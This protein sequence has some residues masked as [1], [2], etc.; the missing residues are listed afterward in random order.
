[1][2]RT[3]AAG[4]LSHIKIVELGSFIAG[5][6]CGQLL[7]DL[8]AEVIK[9]EPPGAGD[10]MRRW[11]A[12]KSKEGL[13][14]WWPVIARNKLSVTLDLRRK[15][16]REAARRLILDADVL[17]ENFR[18]GTL[19][20][21][22]LAPADLQRAKPSLIISRVSAFG[23]TGPY[24][25]RGGFG[26]VAEAAAGL[27]HLTG[28]PDLPPP[29]VGISI[30]DSLAGLF[31][32]IGIL[33][34]LVHRSRSMDRGQ[35][36]DVS[37]A[38]SVLA[39]MESVFS[40]YMETG[41]SRDRTGSILPGIAPSNLYP[42]ANGKLVLIAANADG[43]FLRL[44]AAM[45]MPRLADDP[46]FGTHAARGQHQA[47]LDRIIAAWTEMQS[48]DEIL[49]LMEKAGVPAGPVNDAATVCAD[50]HFRAREMIVSVDA[51]GL[52][53]VT[54]QGV[55]PKLSDSPG[56][57]RWAGPPLGAHNREILGGRLK[58]SPAEIEHLSTATS[59]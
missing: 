45:G 37:I 34:A 53:A 55:V 50:L 58:L 26:S 9:V 39:V 48:A 6:F 21:W 16:A 46:R 43:L 32:A 4:A 54:M 56:S 15:E 51:L 49:G 1:M 38:E 18:P 59:A 19:E 3:P 40:E 36:I 8:G 5:P 52:G 29:R 27:R 7:A 10:A 11:G 44:A 23:Q 31:S 42:T 47:E 14:L 28:F 22:G 30:G 57:I 33:A 25:H 13:S 20:N 17:I 2:N 41:L 24:S 12:Q 35:I